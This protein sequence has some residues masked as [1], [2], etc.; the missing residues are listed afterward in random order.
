M[1]ILLNVLKHKYIP[2]SLF[3]F[4]QCSDE[5][6]KEVQG[7]N[8]IC[9]DGNGNLI[10]KLN[11][12]SLVE[13]NNYI[14]IKSNWTKVSWPINFLIIPKVFILSPCYLQVL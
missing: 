5:C 12:S 8:A 3:T 9:K 1:C 13:K 6:K 2:L 7:V 14:W 11:C 10:N 4:I